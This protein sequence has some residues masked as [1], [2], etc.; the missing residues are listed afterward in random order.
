MHAERLPCTVCL[1]G[2]DTSSR[3]PFRAQTHT[4]T[5][6]TDTLTN[7]TNHHIHASVTDGVGR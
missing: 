6:M 3:F 5:D 4:H 1:P 7:A 2:V